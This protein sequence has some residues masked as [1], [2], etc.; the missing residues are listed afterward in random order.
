[1]KNLRKDFAVSLSVVITALVISMSIAGTGLGISASAVPMSDGID[2]NA[3]TP[4]QAS[5]TITLGAGESGENVG[6]DVPVGKLFVIE[7]VSAYGSAPSDQR[8]D[9]S[10]ATHISPDNT[11]RSH[12][13]TTDRTTGNNRTYYRAS[14]PMKVYGDTPSI[15]TRVARSSSPDSVTFRFTVSG[16]LIDKPVS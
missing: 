1:M 3:Q 10:I 8:I 12:Y 4:Y 11:N 13:L 14:Q 9:L 7:H 6:I 5:T 15:T 2:L 16:Y